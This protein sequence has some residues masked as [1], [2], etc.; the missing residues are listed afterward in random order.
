MKTRIE[1]WYRNNEM[2]DEENKKEIENE[3]LS[4]NCRIIDLQMRKHYEGGLVFYV[5][6]KDPNHGNTLQTYKPKPTS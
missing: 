4:K 5:R 6:Y 2:T 1:F 3:L